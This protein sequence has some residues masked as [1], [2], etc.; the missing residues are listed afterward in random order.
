MIVDKFTKE[1]SQD[2]AALLKSGDCHVWWARPSDANK[3]LHALLDPKERQR[4]EAFRYQA[5]RDRFVV[6]CGLTRLVLARYLH[7]SP[8]VIPILR[9]CRNCGG[10]HGKPE[11]SPSSPATVEFSVSHSGSCIVVAFSLGTPVGVDVEEVRLELPVEGL[12]EQALTPAE[13]E[14]LQHLE[15]AKRHTEFLHYWTKKEAVLKATEYGF[16]ISPSSFSVSGSGELPRLITWPL[17]DELV[18]R[19]SLHCLQPGTGYVASLAIIGWCRRV[20]DLDGS[21]LIAAAQKIT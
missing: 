12:A 10:P 11:L 2:D 1:F 3:R 21:T 13:M 5:D 16:T 18:N 8:S 19:L 14:R 17:K 7:Q 20:V 4:L 6:A 9:E 15:L